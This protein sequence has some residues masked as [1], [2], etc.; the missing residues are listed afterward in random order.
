MKGLFLIVLGFSE[1]LIIGSALVAFLLVLQIIPRLIR[2]GSSNQY[3]SI[4]QFL[5]VLGAITATYCQFYTWRLPQIYI[6]NKVLIILIGFIFGIFVG[7]IAAALT[8]TLKALP[9]LSRRVKIAD[10]I[11]I[12][13]AVIILGKVIGSLIYWLSPEL[14]F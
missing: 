14:W 11:E 9:I 8:E 4:Y 10:K 6:F 12:L 3:V 2:F 1:G 5:V 13:L 7:L